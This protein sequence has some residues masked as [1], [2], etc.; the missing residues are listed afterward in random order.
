MTAALVAEALR[1]ENALVAAVYAPAFMRLPKQGGDWA[2]DVA[3]VLARMADEQVVVQHL[4]F[5]HSAENLPL[6]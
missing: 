3:F 5:A 6:V 2:D 1:F 4:C